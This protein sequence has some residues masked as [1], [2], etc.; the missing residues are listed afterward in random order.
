M[1]VLNKIFTKKLCEK[2]V[3][4]TDFG[5]VVGRVTVFGHNGGTERCDEQVTK[6]AKCVQD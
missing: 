3:E 1:I 2:V 4:K 6:C 5:C